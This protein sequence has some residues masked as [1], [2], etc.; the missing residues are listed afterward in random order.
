MAGHI[1]VVSGADEGPL[2]CYSEPTTISGWNHCACVLTYACQEAGLCK[3][4]QVSVCACVNTHC[5]E[6]AVWISMPLSV[7]G[8]T[9][10]DTGVMYMLLCKAHE[11]I[12]QRALV[13]G[14]SSA[15]HWWIIERVHR[16][17]HSLR[18]APH[19]LCNHSPLL[20]FLGFR[21]SVIAVSLHLIR[22]LCF[23]DTRIKSCC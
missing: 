9:S 18:L 21:V 17:L 7:S 16:C 2:G 12:S 5:R 6:C 19:L 14:V 20:S 3:H 11:C 10:E 4:P 15:Q 8:N 1:Q 13:T 22:F 23:F